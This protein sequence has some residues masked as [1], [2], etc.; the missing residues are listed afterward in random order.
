[1][2]QLIHCDTEFLVLGS[3]YVVA[4]KFK[5]LKFLVHYVCTIDCA[6]ATVP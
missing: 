4:I 2:V 6:V 3:V 5:T 1:M